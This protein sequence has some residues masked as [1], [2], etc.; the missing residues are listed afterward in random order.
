MTHDNSYK[1]SSGKR[2]DQVLSLF[3]PG[4]ELRIETVQKRIGISYMNACMVLRR[5]AE[6]GHLVRVNAYR[7]PEL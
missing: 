5:L 2:M 1:G 7:R 4:E 3:G 6:S